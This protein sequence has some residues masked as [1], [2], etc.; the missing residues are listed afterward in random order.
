MKKINS[1]QFGDTKKEAD[2]LLNLVLTRKKKATS[3]LYDS[4][5]KR[6]Q[7]F[8]KIGDKSMVKDSKNIPRCLIA[9]TN[10]KVK[11]FGKISAAFARKE[12]EGDQSLEYWRKTHK[13][14]FMKRLNKMKKK[15]NE[16]ILVVC[17]EFKV[18]KIF[19]H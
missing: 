16:N 1:W 13:R 12:G 2:Y 11:H 18:I 10:V 17:E 15:F 5:I 4:Y 3:S 19:G 7:S 8:P 9:I 14:F 6:K